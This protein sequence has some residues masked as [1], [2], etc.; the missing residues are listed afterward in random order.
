HW[1]GGGVVSKRARDILIDAL[2]NHENGHVKAKVPGALAFVYNRITDENEKDRIVDALIEAATGGSL[3]VEGFSGIIPA[4]RNIYAIEVLGKWIKAKKTVEPLIEALK[5]ENE[6]VRRDA[7]R[8][9]A[10][11]GDKRAVEP[12]IEAFKEE[13]GWNRECIAWQLAKLGDKRAVKPLEEALTDPKNEMIKENIARHLKA[14]N[15]KIVTGK[16]YQY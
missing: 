15:F 8:A 3:E 13:E 9:L 14:L 5:D 1:E 6:Q 16:D 11:I 4:H 2:K 7:A 12:L 10:D